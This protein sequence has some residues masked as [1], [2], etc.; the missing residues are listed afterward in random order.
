MTSERDIEKNII[1]SFSKHAK[2]YDRHAQLQKSMA[3]RLA[4][5]LPDP[6]PPRVLEIGCGTGV[7]TRHLLARPVRN[8][9]LNDI[10]PTMIEQLKSRLVLPE[11]TRI[12]V[13]N[14]CKMKFPPVDLV[15]ANAVFQW[16]R[17]PQ[18]SLAH[19]VQSLPP[20]GK[21]VF[22]TFGPGTLQEFRRGTSLESPANLLS[23]KR[24]KTILQDIGLKNENSFQEIRETFST[25]TLMLMKSLQQIGA[26][27]IR[28]VKSG[29]LRKLMREYDEAFSTPQGVR[30]T[31]EIFYFSA[32]R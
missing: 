27:P 7:F 14:A 11:L 32:S 13:G 3:E 22:S 26:A 5:L 21:L 23:V 15:A 16:F 29:G 4:T 1:D 9:Y 28:M 2:S 18:E 20:G 24:W 8:L 10:S 12:V 17:N 25:S 30:A 31:W 19:L 6:L